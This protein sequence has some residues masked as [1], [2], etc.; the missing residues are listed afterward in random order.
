MKRRIF[1]LSLVGM[2]AAAT[3][4]TGTALAGLNTQEKEMT[5]LEDN[6]ALV[7]RYFELLAERDWDSIEAMFHDDYV[8]HMPAQPA[9]LP[10]DHYFDAVKMFQA[11]FPDIHH[12]VT[13][14]I[15]ERDKVM[16]QMRITGTHQGDLMGVP[17]SGASIDYG[18]IFVLQIA[19]GQIIE[20]WAEADL[21]GLMQQINPSQ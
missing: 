20:G 14:T 9:P 5:N 7:G 11:A 8:F 21:M 15:A 4:S 10:K 12:G 18:T 17:A 2:A 13:E 19:D 1:N 6:K 16:V 3:M